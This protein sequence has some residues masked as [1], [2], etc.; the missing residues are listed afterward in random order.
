[1]GARFFLRQKVAIEVDAP[2]GEIVGHSIPLLLIGS[3]ID[4]GGGHKEQARGVLHL[5]FICELYENRCVGDGT[6]FTHIRITKTVE[7][8][9][10]WWNS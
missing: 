8:S 6:F 4:F 5:V 9:Q 7:I 10:Q 2:N 3:P 1:M